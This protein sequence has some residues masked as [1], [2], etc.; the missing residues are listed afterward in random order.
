ML[1]L[2]QYIQKELQRYCDQVYADQA[3]TDEQ[4]AAKYQTYYA[5]LTEPFA[6]RA[7]LKQAQEED[8]KA[9]HAA[10]LA[11]LARAAQFGMTTKSA[12]GARIRQAR[13]QAGLSQTDLGNMLGVSFGMIA[14][15]EAGRKLPSDEKLELLAKLFEIP[16]EIK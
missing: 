12:I 15:Y 5:A 1:I 13:K 6:E 10:R 3:L 9:N 11:V 8:K 14:H 4:S 2:P 7:R 16:F